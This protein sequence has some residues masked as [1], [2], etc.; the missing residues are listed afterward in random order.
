M[1]DHIEAMARAICVEFYCTPWE[2]TSEFRRAICREVA[3]AAWAAAQPKVR[4]IGGAIADAILE[5]LMGR[6][7]LD[8]EFDNIDDEVWDEIREAHAAIVS[9]VMEG[10]A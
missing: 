8:H 10:N 6:K 1:T 4:E 9:R 5:D 7:G 2:R 3:V